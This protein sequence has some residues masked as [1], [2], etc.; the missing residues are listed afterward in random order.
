MDAGREIGWTY[1]QELDD[2]IHLSVR[3]ITIQAMGWSAFAQV[4]RTWNLLETAGT[5]IQTSSL[6]IVIFEQFT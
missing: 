2:S 4:A 1:S 6:R 3:C 5:G